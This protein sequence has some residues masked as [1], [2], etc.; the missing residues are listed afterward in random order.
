M[1]DMSKGTMSSSGGGGAE[2]LATFQ[3]FG[4]EVNLLHGA[5]KQPLVYAVC[6]DTTAVHAD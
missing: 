5:A 3:G 6:I 1:T 2:Q 4:V